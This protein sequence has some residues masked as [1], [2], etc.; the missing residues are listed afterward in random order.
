MQTQQIMSE[1]HSKTTNESSPSTIIHAIL[2]ADDLPPAEAD[3]N[4]VNDEVSTITGAGLET[5]AQTLRFTV[6]HLYTNPPPL[7]HLLRTESQDLSSSLNHK[8]QSEP[9]LAQ[10]ERLPYLTAVI[11]E[12]LR[13]GDAARTGS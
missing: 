13:L 9:T 8:T 4:R 1:I 7:L 11:I 2:Q 5:V 12:G 10:L 6:Y 3:L